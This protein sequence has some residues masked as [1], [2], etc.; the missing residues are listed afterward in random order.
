M[1]LA[2]SLEK[3]A[4]NVIEA[5]GADVTIRYVTA[6]TYNTTTGVI[7]ETESDTAIKGVVENI[8]QSEVNELIQASD[9]R[10]IVA[11]KELATA[12]ETKDRVVISSVVHQIIQVETI[13]QDNTAITYELVLRA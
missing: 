1:G 10:L 7:G 8:K 2:S 9:K 4:S 3:V 5:L 13:D 6:G 11:A 12:P